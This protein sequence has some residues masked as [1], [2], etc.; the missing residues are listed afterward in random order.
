MNIVN[1]M[2]DLISM[3]NII[4][5]EYTNNPQN[6]DNDYHQKI[7]HAT[8]LIIFFQTNKRNEK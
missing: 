6:Y 2:N 7:F 5:G 4:V 1:N 8:K 3:T